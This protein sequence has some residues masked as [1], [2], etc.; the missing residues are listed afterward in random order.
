MA[1]LSQ[2]EIL[3]ALGQNP[4]VAAA[5]LTV[6]LWPLVITIPGSNSFRER[7]R[8]LLSQRAVLVLLIAGHWAYLLLRSL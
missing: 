6:L 5:A 3:T 8:Y 7:A 1:S 4:L 2:G